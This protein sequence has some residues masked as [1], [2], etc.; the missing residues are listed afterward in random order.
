MKRIKRPNAVNLELEDLL[1][2][3]YGV[4]NTQTEY[5]IDKLERLVE[6]LE[7]EIDALNDV[8]MDA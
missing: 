5:Y 6:T 2:C 8:K 4:K 7:R 1:G 3:Y